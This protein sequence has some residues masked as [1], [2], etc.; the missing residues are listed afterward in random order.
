MVAKFAFELVSPERLVFSQEAEMVVIPGSDGNFGVLRGHIPL[1]SAIRSGVIDL[2]ETRHTNPVRIFVT[3]GFVEV[4]GDRCTVLVEE[5]TPVTEIDRATIDQ[6]ISDLT[7]DLADAKD[8][9]ERRTVKQALAIAQ[10]RR[11]AAAST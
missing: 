6:Q 4:T 8:E 2:Y 7:E 9:H 5:A 11:A 3:G 10:A 1:I